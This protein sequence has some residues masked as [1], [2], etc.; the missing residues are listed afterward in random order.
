M[1]SAIKS[2]A[3]EVSSG[4]RVG[5]FFLLE[6]DLFVQLF[7]EGWQYPLLNQIDRETNPLVVL[8]DEGKRRRA[9]ARA[10]DERPTFIDFL[11]SAFGEAKVR[12]L[13]RKYNCDKE[14]NR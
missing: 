14:C 13:C 5:R 4:I 3:F 12:R 7:A 9:G 10:D 6:F 11:Q 2:T 1:V 8:I